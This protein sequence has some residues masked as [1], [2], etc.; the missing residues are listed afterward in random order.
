MDAAQASA[1]A[2]GAVMKAIQAIENS[3]IGRAA[4]PRSGDLS[5][6]HSM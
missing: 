5:F 2:M 6:R 3:A 4:H 1:D